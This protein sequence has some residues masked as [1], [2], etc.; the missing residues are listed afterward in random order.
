MTRKKEH[1]PKTKD[2]KDAEKVTKEVVKEEKVS[3]PAT[4]KPAVDIDD[5]F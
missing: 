5:L 3:A 2:E 1:P 4:S